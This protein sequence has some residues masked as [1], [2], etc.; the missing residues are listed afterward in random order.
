MATVQL[1][2][3]ESR[4]KHGHSAAYRADILRQ[5]WNC[6]NPSPRPLRRRTRP[7]GAGR[8]HLL[9]RRHV[10]RRRPPTA[11]ARRPAEPSH[12]RPNARRLLRARA[13]SPGSGR[14]HRRRGA[15]RRPAPPPA[16]PPA[17][18][19]AASPP[20]RAGADPRHRGHRRLGPAP[21]AASLS[22]LSPAK[23]VRDAGEHLC[24]ELELFPIEIQ[25]HCSG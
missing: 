25:I 21:P 4:A 7:G 12:R 22:L 6:P 18:P 2:T 17:G 1:D 20:P 10:A 8:V 23:D 15:V 24:P 11:A 13:A 5:A 14:A 9:H 19:A 16:D 3:T